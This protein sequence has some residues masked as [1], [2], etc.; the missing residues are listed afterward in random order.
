M[1]RL[2]QSHHAFRAVRACSVYTTRFVKKK[3]FFRDSRVSCLFRESGSLAW[4][5]TFLLSSCSPR[6]LSLSY[7]ALFNTYNSNK[8][9][10]CPTN[11]CHEDCPSQQS[12]QDDQGVLRPRHEEGKF[13]LF[14]RLNL[15]GN[16]SLVSFPPPTSIYR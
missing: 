1:Y 9:V 10:R 6:M 12:Q 2:A 3:N 7:S 16:L 13:V 15:G 5:R 4:K 8:N 11:F 14:L